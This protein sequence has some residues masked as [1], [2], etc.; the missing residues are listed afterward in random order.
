MVPS[1]PYDIVFPSGH[2]RYR[3][4]D[5]DKELPALTG[6]RKA[7]VITDEQVWKHHQQLLKACPVI[8][9]PAIHAAK[10]WNTVAQ[11]VNELIKLDA[12]RKTL[13]VG[14]GGGTITDLTGFVASIFMRGIP[15]GFVP[16]TVLALADAAIG[17]KNGIDHEAYKNLLGVIRQPEFIL[18]DVQFLRT[19]PAQ[20]WRS[21]FTEIIKYG[22]IFDK[23]LFRDL[24]T[25]SIS[26]YQEN[27]EAL[28]ALLACCMQWKNKT[29]LED[30]REQGVRKLLNFGHTAGH[31][32]EKHYDLPH[33]FGIALGMVVACM[34]SEK[35]MQIAP[36][37]RIRLVDLLKRYELPHHQPLDVEAVM[38]LLRMDKKKS[39]G[40]VDYI[41]LEALGAATVR[42]LSFY[43]I[44]QALRRFSDD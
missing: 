40:R 16:T 10:Q 38:T 13:L 14:L 27:P 33:G 5:F 18:S 43:Q 28:D 36:S 1:T 6:D 2:V 30:E 4:G 32:I 44:E 39:D 22:C 19:L 29:V 24:E 31:A 37:I 17:G 7:I 41:V 12:D 25:G 11:I 9:V 3:F 21:G 20:E 34:L 26:F 23:A 8:V 15:F 35:V 42:Q